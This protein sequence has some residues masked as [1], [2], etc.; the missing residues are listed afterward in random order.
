MREPRIYVYIYKYI[1]LSIF[2]CINKMS[3]YIYM[4]KIYVYRNIQTYV[5]VNIHILENILNVCL[6]RYACM[7]A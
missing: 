3:V 4:Q 1:Y 6:Y 5:N 7:R 2:T